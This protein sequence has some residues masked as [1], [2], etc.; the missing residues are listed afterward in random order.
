MLMDVNVSKGIRVVIAETTRMAGRLL[1]DALGQQGVCD[2]VAT[3]QAAETMSVIAGVR[4]AVVLVSETLEDDPKRGFQLAREIRSA[5]PEV[6][7]VMLLD[8]CGP[9]PVV[10]AFRAGARGVFSRNESLKDLALCISRVSRGEISAKS[11]HIRLAIEA[12]A[13][14]PAK[15]PRDW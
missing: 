15:Q 4:P 13:S 1:A 10:E 11:E 12:L 8:G 5:W 2:A 9:E 14:T 3:S 6:Q 7:M